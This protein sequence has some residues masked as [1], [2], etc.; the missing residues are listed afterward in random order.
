MILNEQEPLTPSRVERLYR[1]IL[2]N[3]EGWAITNTGKFSKD[4]CQVLHQEWCS[5]GY[6][7]RSGTKTLEC[8]PAERDLGVLVDGKLCVS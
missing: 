3:C 7:Y 4:K 8:S 6:T 2:I 1:E 5:P